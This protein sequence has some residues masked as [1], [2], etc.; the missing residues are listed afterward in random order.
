MADAKYPSLVT[1][2]GYFRIL[3]WLTNVIVVVYT[4]V[5]L[6]QVL[7]NGTF[8]GGGLFGFV[9]AVLGATLGG[10]V[11]VAVYGL[12]GFVVATIQFATSE[13]I[14]VLVDIEANTRKK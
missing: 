9:G 12:I 11:V 14:L 13:A 6:I 10:I 8:F 7:V 4:I 5:G 1:I 3:G 2:A